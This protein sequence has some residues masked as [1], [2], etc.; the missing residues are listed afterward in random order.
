MT[1]I[2][3]S[4]ISYAAYLIARDHDDGTFKLIHLNA[5]PFKKE[6]NKG[7]CDMYLT[8]S[9]IFSASFPAYYL[10]GAI[11]WPTVVCI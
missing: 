4:L 11:D 9:T 2:L 5:P 3:V 6:Q 10:S 1:I 8:V 7:S